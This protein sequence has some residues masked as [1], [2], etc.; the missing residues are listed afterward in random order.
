MGKWESGRLN[1]LLLPKASEQSLLT[2]NEMPNYLAYKPGPH[3][4][5]RSLFSIWNGVLYER[6]SFKQVGLFSIIEKSKYLD[7]QKF[8]AI[9]QLLCIQL[10]FKKFSLLRRSKG[11]DN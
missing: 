5:D 8:R 1:D 7:N 9:R 6:R 2:H 4:S 11:T 3:R 10:S